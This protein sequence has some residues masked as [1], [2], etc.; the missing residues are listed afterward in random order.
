MESGFLGSEII[1][2]HSIRFPKSIIK[3]KQY[4]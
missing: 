2:K 1:A 4:G 3:G